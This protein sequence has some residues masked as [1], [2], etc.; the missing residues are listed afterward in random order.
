MRSHGSWPA[1][2]PVPGLARNRFPR[3]TVHQA[4]IRAFWM[5][6]SSWVSTPES[7][8]SPSCLSWASGSAASGAGGGAG[9]GSCAYDCWGASCS[10][11]RWS[12]RRETRLLTAVAVPA[13]AAVRATPRSNPGMVLLSSVGGLGRFERRED[14]LN[15]QTAAGDELAAGLPQ[16]DRDRR[17][18]AVLPHE[19]GGGRAGLPGRGSLFDVL[20]SEEPAGGAVELAPATAAAVD[21]AD[22]QRRDGA[23]L[24][25][26]QERD[27]EDPDDAAVDEVDDQRHRLTGRLP[28]RPLDHDVV[29]RAHLFELFHAH[30]CLL[31]RVS[32]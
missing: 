19:H 7:L 14:G 1:P 27:V 6:N 30:G 12:W 8:S 5:A 18:P 28:A 11:Q 32:R 10:A 22:V 21:L 31:T 24:A 3:P 29:D 9:G 26:H 20:V 16:R 15:W 13:T 23:V 4:R 25:L 2:G 17:G